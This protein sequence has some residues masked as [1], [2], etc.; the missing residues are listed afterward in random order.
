MVLVAADRHI[1]GSS[2]E[3][4]SSASQRVFPRRRSRWR[5]NGRAHRRSFSWRVGPGRHMALSSAGC[6][7]G[8][9]GVPRAVAAPRT[10]HGT[11]EAV[12]PALSIYVGNWRTHHGAPRGSGSRRWRPS[13]RHADT[14]RG[15]AVRTGTPS[16]RQPQHQRVNQRGPIPLRREL[17][18]TAV[19]RIRYGRPYI[20]GRS[21]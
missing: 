15:T 14:S 10:P 11:E 9:L 12:A 21:S 13:G 7:A 19:R 6:S 3:V 18:G 5:S 8:A 4:R 2:I 20:K 1:I 17:C 16:G